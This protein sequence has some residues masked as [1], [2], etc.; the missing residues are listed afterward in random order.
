VL[1]TTHSLQRKNISLARHIWFASFGVVVACHAHLTRRH[2]PSD[3]SKKENKKENCEI[4]CQK[5]QTRQILKRKEK[6]TQVTEF[7]SSAL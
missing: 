5:K 1:P 3:L 2:S 6:K 7:V 4:V